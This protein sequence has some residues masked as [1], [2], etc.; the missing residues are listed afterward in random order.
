MKAPSF[1]AVA[2][3]VL[4]A[5]A[6]SGPNADSKTSAT[7]DVAAT[8]AS[9]T[10]SP[11]APMPRPEASPAD[12]AAYAKLPEETR[13]AIENADVVVA[14]TLADAKIASVLEIAPPI[15]V[16]E[17]DVVVAERI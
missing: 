1:T 14:A 12:R 8:D 13:R 10:P 16:H 9:A 5:A 7:I 17:F 3:A 15:F 2:L 4:L 6:C 11:L